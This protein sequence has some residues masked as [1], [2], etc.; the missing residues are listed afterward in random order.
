MEFRTVVGLTVTNGPGTLSAKGAKESV[1]A[2]NDISM[3][4]VGFLANTG[5]AH[6]GNGVEAVEFLINTFEGVPLED[7]GR[8]DHGIDLRRSRTGP[9]RPTRRSGSGAGSRGRARRGRSRASTTRCSAGR[10]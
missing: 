6:G 9:R 10:T 8:R 3:G 1:S 5:R 2:R 7:P 4:Y